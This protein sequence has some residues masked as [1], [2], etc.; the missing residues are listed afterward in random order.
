M[1]VFHR[2]WLQRESKK[3]F[4]VGQVWYLISM[5]WWNSWIEYVTPQVSDKHPQSLFHSNFAF[6]LSDFRLVYSKIFFNTN[7]KIT[8]LLKMMLEFI[9]HLCV[10]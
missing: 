7:I 1:V 4:E 8:I 9:L 6:N 3:A 2:Q 5:G 10:L